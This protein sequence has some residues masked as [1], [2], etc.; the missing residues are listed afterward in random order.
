MIHV[1]LCLFHVKEKNK[2][3][4]AITFQWKWWKE[5]NIVLKD[6]RKLE[7]KME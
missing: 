3:S 4:P 2:N 5:K 1:C 7:K 6:D